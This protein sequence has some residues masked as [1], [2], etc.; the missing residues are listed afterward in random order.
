ME[1]NYSAILKDEDEFGFFNFLI[2]AKVFNKIYRLLVDLCYS[3]DYFIES[4]INGLDIDVLDLFFDEI[5]KSL[6]KLIVNKNKKVENGRY[7]LDLSIPIE[8]IKSNDFILEE[9]DGCLS[10]VYIDK[11]NVNLFPFVDPKKL[12]GGY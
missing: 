1:I 2:E 11:C 10:G 7:N 9:R 4:T 3:L 6:L 5:Q 8:N 12:I